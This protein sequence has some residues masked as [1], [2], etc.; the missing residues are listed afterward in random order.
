MTPKV[1]ILSM[2]HCSNSLGT[3]NDVKKFF[4]A[5]KSR[6]V[7]TILDA[8]QSISCLPIDVKNLCCDFMVFSAHKLF[9]PYGLGVLWGQED[10][11]NRLP[12]YRG[13]GSMIESVDLD[14]S[15]YLK[16]PHRFEAGTPNIEAVIGFGAAIDFFADLKWSEVAAHEAS[17]LDRARL[18]L[19]SIPGLRVFTPGGEAKNILT[20]VADWGHSSDIGQLL[21]QQG[22]AVR[23]G[24]HC[25]QPL[26]KRLGVTA[27]VRASFSIYSDESDVEQLVHG[28]NKAKELLS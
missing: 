17:I 3:V 14:Q 16:A 2:V 21:D 28:I 22:I 6:S 25:T 7:I 12:P 5:A 26:M 18:G 4:V 1:K 11:L 10:L 23:T 13:G 9:A 8:A 27:T 15:T 19:K 20:F 24:H